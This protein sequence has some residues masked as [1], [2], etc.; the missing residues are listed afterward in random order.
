MVAA[1]G[2]GTDTLSSFSLERFLMLDATTITP[3]STLHDT[4]IACHCFK[5]RMNCCNGVS[6]ADGRRFASQME[7]QL[8]AGDAR[9]QLLHRP[10]RAHALRC[11][12]T[13]GLLFLQERPGLVVLTIELEGALTQMPGSLAP[14]RLWS[15]VPHQIL[16]G[17][18]PSRCAT[19]CVLF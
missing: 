13:L 19:C 18:K 14:S 11:R 17:C 5:H 8:P 7:H 9:S 12:V 15:P 6:D 16:S 2:A 3:N 1:G 10:H 4:H